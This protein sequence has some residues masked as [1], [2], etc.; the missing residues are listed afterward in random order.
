MA[1]CTSLL[2]VAATRAG[3]EPATLAIGARTK[4]FTLPAGSG[5]SLSLEDVR[6]AQATVIVF[7][8]FDCPI[9]MSYTPTLVDLSKKYA[10]QGVKLIGI[11]C[12]PVDAQALTQPIQDFAIPFPVLKDD[13]CRVAGQFGARTTPE[14]FLLDHDLVLRYRGRID[15]AY[16]SRS[17][18]NS[19]V[20]TEDLRLALEAVLTR[21]AIVTPITKP[22]GC[23]IALDSQAVGTSARITYYH[24]VVPILQKN[25][26]S[27]HRPGEVGPLSLM[28]YRQAA[29]WA[30]DIKELTQSRKMPPWKP[31][32]GPPFQN[33][34]K[35]TGQEVE[36]LAAW[37]NAGAPEGNPQDAPPARQFVDGW[38]LGP[39]DLV[40]Q[41]AGDMHVGPRGQDLFRCFVL[42]TGL[43]EDKCISA[44][45]VR[46]GNKR[47]VH[48]AL[49]FVDASGQGR[50]LELAS[51][52][53]TE[54]NAADRGPGYTTAM[55]VGFAPR[56]GMG[57]WAPGMIGKNLPDG[58]GYFLPKGS[59]VV[60]QVHYHRDGREETD[61]TRI[62]LY[63]AR[64]PVTKQYQGIVV[65]GSQAGSRFFLVPPGAQNFRVRGSVWVE[66]DCEIYSVMPH[67][68]LIGRAIKV[69]MTP[70]GKTP[71]TLI[72]LPDWDYS[73]QEVYFFAEPIH[74]SAGTRFDIEAVY[75]NSEQ[76]PNNPNDPP[77]LVTFGEQTTNE[78]CFGFIGAASETPGRIR[79][80]TKPPSPLT[81]EKQPSAPLPAKSP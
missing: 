64:K 42:P 21:D 52:A 66:Q 12:D 25:C 74:A 73:W 53:K 75:D 48:H 54:R 20:K 14:A 81:P 19:K 51:A 45:E 9:C 56:S 39:P 29:R 46:P 34:R 10:P 70:P 16:S 4:T 13:G 7:L 79:Q 68:H 71:I 36:T 69:T 30:A 67:M 28:T 22:I 27:C 78:M 11:V 18:K 17:K 38:Q 15:D 60:L 3:N 26:Q 80:R 1:S 65:A 40:L 59:D 33:E 2:L 63:F 23:P 57:G 41:I 58:T 77:R 47:I 62:G 24:D 61:R 6:G 72:D 49:L 55:G 37:A 44:V 31:T 8:S 76:N 35:L 5:R 32:Q 43:T 50:Q